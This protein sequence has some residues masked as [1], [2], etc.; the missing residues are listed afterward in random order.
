MY[1]IHCTLY[2]YI[3]VYVPQIADV[4][5]E[6]LVDEADTHGFFSF[7]ET[8]FSYVNL[9]T[10]QE[11]TCRLPSNRSKFPLC[12]QHLNS[13]Y[14]LGKLEAE[15]VAATGKIFPVAH[16]KRHNTVLLAR[17]MLMCS[18]GPSAGLCF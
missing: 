4:Y 14:L 1:I 16:R 15:E 18:G 17:T 8:I 11:N 5:E 3:Y 6:P 7:H 10:E 9:E 2:I 13:G 12:F